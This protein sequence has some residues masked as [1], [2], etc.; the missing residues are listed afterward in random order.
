MGMG[1]HLFCPL[2]RKDQGHTLSFCHMWISCPYPLCNSVLCSV[3]SVIAPVGETVSSITI[4]LRPSDFSASQSLTGYNHLF[5]ASRN[6]FLQ[7]MPATHKSIISSQARRSSFKNP[8]R[9]MAQWCGQGW[10][11]LHCGPAFLE[12]ILYICVAYNNWPCVF[13]PL[14]FRN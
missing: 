1:L 12:I 3:Y 8:L 2:L 13:L 10:G 11:L 4:L 5:L 9:T 6:L 14:C 7:T